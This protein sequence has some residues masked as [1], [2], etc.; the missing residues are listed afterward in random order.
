[1]CYLCNELYKVTFYDI[2]TGNTFIKKIKPLNYEIKRRIIF[3]DYGKLPAG[4]ILYCVKR[5]KR[6]E[7]WIALS[8]PYRLYDRLPIKCGTHKNPKYNEPISKSYN[9][10]ELTTLN[11]KNILKIGIIGC[12]IGNELINEYKLLIPNTHEIIKTTVVK[13]SYLELL[14]VY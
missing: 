10:C 13:D 7:K 1:M 8:P 9:F 2:A 12:I 14:P 11:T 3:G 4:T 5:S 6:T